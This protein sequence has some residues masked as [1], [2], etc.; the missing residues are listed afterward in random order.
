MQSIN[1]LPRPEVKS[2]EAA[3]IVT[4]ANTLLVRVANYIKENIDKL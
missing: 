1:D 3:S 4:N 2:I